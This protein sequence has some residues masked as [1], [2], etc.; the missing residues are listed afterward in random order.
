MVTRVC[1]ETGYTTKILILMV[2]T[3]I[4]NRTLQYRMDGKPM[5]VPDFV[6]KII[7]G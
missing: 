7:H 4:N 5:I 1:P 2:K 3:M 6:G